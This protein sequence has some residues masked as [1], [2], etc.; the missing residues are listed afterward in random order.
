MLE[1]R[2]C[3]Q[4]VCNSTGLQK[5]K[6]FHP[7]APSLYS[8]HNNNNGKRYEGTETTECVQQVMGHYRKSLVGSLQVDSSRNH[9]R[10]GVSKQFD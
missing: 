8:D 10:V 7:T 4:L 6:D 3:A 1:I 2:F 5:E 9:S